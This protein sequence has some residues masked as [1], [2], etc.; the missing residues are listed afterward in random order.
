MTPEDEQAF[1]VMQQ[2]VQLE[3]AKR[4][5]AETKVSQ[6]SG[7]E[8]GKEPNIIEY[9][10]DISKTLDRIY[11]QL[12]GH[13]IK[14]LPNGAEKWEEPSDD[15]LK[16]LSDYGVKQ[17]MNLLSMYISPDTLLANLTE[18]QVYWI[19]L[20][21]G[22]ELID[23]M[24]C[25]YELFYSY[26]SPEELFD[27]YKPIVKENNLNISDHELYFKCVQ[28][29]REEL[30]MKFRHFPM[31]VNMIIHKVFINLTRA[32]NGEERESLRK[33]YN[34]HQSLQGPQPL[35][36]TNPAQKPSLFKPSTWNK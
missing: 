27:K 3:Q 14:I 19:T 5:E 6:M 21:F 15:R 30:Q 29:S 35:H 28:W 11:H 9:Q 17:I 26:P 33:Q 36:Y 16:I 1:L 13:V 7:F 10:L 24:Y 4:M 12:S 23:L 8:A 32:I 25:R 34:I 31:Q 2:Q 20:D 22:V 18:D